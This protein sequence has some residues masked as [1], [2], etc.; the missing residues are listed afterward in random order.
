MGVKRSHLAFYHQITK[1]MKRAFC[2]F[3]V[4]SSFFSAHGQETMRTFAQNIINGPADILYTSGEVNVVG[5]KQ[6]GFVIIANDEIAPTLLGYSSERFCG[7]GNPA[8]QWYLKAANEAIA[9]SKGR[10]H[11]PLIPSGNFKPEVK[12]LITTEWAQGTP[13][14]KLCP[15]LSGRTPYPTGCVATAMAQIMNYWKYPSQ[16]QGEATLSVTVDGIGSIIS[17]DFSK[18]TY[19]WD[20]MLDYFQSGEYTDEQADAIAQLMLHCG[21]G[22]G[23]S[24]SPTGSGTQSRQARTALSRYFKYNPNID[25]LHRDFFSLEQWMH[26]LYTEFNEG[27][28]VY[29]AAQ[30]TNGDSGHAF[31]I[32]GYDADGLVHVNWGWGP[33]S[34]NGYYDLSLLEVSNSKFSSGQEVLTHIAPTQINDYH[35]HIVCN[36]GISCSLFGKKLRF[37]ID[38][39]YNMTGDK[40]SGEA[41][42]VMEHEGKQ[43]LLK[44]EPFTEVVHFSA[45][46]VSLGG[47]YTLPADLEDG[48]YRIYAAAKTQSDADWRPIH[49]REGYG[50]HAF[51]TLSDGVPSNLRTSESDTWVGLPLLKSDRQ[52][53]V[54]KS[55]DLYDLSGRR[56]MRPRNGIFVLSGRKVVLQQ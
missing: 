49:T 55:S 28:P 12:P 42:L 33:D 44:T 16:G 1:N 23:M 11:T 37:S 29:Y 9:H 50:N 10:K 26:M 17:A 51:L 54:T 46:E 35:S 34:G 31:I 52:T 36:G 6:G 22:A 25:L 38:M 15:M 45:V 56:V 53:N 30:D 20:L 27:R 48:N 18:A 21:I 40:V 24:Y 14:N 2:V 39:L 5:R 8:L 7:E 3:F 19:R 4:I 41:A 32:D 47:L 43:Y 13:Y